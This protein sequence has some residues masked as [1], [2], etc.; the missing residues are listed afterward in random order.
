MGREHFDDFLMIQKI[1]YAYFAETLKNI[2]GISKRKKT[3]IDL[4][5]F[6]YILGKRKKYCWYMK[7]KQDQ[8]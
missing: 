6:T 1:S 5:L 3:Y 8:H 4:P 7:N 2:A